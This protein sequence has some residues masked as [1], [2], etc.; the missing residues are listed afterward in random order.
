MLRKFLC[1]RTVKTVAQDCLPRKVVSMSLSTLRWTTLV[2]MLIVM[3]PGCGYFGGAAS[4]EDSDLTAMDGDKASSVDDAANAL[5][6]DSLPDAQALELK[7]DVGARF[8]LMK[9]VETRLTQNDKSGISVNTSRVEMMLSLVVDEVRPDGSKVLTARYHRVQYDQDV[10]GKRVSYS[11]ERSTEP[12]PTEALLYSGLANNGF[13]FRLGPNNKIVELMGFNDFLHRC[14][15]NVPPDQAAS[16]QQQLEAIKSQDGIANFIDES[17]GLLPYSDDPAH[18]AVA[19]KVGMNWDLEA[20]RIDVPIPMVATMKCM[21][22]ELNKHSAEITMVGSIKGPPNLVKMFAA[23][24]EVSIFVRG[25]NCT[26]SCLVDRAT[27]MPMRSEINR[28]LDMIVE[29]HDGNK[30]QQNKSTLSTITSF[31]DQNPRSTQ[32]SERPLQTPARVTQASEKRTTGS[33]DDADPHVN[34]LKN[35]FGER[36]RP[37]GPAGSRP[38]F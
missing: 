21:L 31:L 30:I 23:D 27:G 13:S 18:P 9:T 2:T 36:N 10:A 5:S 37:V 15:R 35:A 11:S 25:G 16:V 8:P 34:L 33:E 26:G 3:L 12:V 6:M 1:V 4:D 24:G 38:K 20:R 7:L 28:S 29:T 17:I 14:L 19:V 32:S 22:K